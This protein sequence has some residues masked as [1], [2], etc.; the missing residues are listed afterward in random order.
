MSAPTDETRQTAE[1]PPIRIPEFDFADRVAK[2]RKMMG[3]TQTEF[4]DQLN[5]RPGTLA[6][7]ESGVQ[8]RDMVS[9]A[10]KV[11]AISSVPV[12]WILGVFTDPDATT[13]NPCFV[14]DL[15]WQSVDLTDSHIPHQR[16]HVDQP[17]SEP[18]EFCVPAAPDFGTA[19]GRS[20][21]RQRRHAEPHRGPRDTRP[22]N[23]ATVTTAA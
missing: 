19:P 7:W 5:T 23:R 3:L 13:Q 17:A 22:P 18:A 8:P 9:V 10:R 6:G 11:S 21:P 1:R 12:G 4:A 14:C 2:V 15:S 20:I 16:E